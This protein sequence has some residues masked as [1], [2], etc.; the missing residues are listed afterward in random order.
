M[1]KFRR[2]IGFVMV[3]TLFFSLLVLPANA[4]SYTYNYEKE[5]VET[6]EAVVVEKYLDF[7]NIPCGMLSSPEDMDIDNK[8]N[9]YISDTEN[10]RIVILNQDLSF[11]KTITVL[12]GKDGKN[13]DIKAPNGIF[14]ADSGEIYIACSGNNRVFVTN[15]GK[16]LLRT[17][18]A[19]AKDVM[20]DTFT[21]TPLKVAADSSGRTFVIADGVYDGLMQF[22]P[23]GTFIGFSGS[24]KVTYNIIDLFWMWFGTEKQ[25]K[26]RIKN[27]PVEFDGLDMD[28][29]GFV[30]TASGSVDQW[31]P[32][33]SEPIRRQTNVGTNIL[34]FIDELGNPI[35]DIEYPYET[36]EAEVTGPSRLIDISADCSYGY[37]ALDS[38]RGR[39]FVYNDNGDLMFAFGGL[40]GKQGEFV[41]PSAV[42]AT[43]DRIYV[44]DKGTGAVT[45]F[46]FSDYAKLII[47]AQQ[48]YF[49]GDYEQSK[50]EYEEILKLNSGLDLAYAGLGKILILEGDYS[51]AMEYLRFGKNKTYYSKAFGEYRS[52][53]MSD[54]FLIILIIAIIF[55]TLTVLFV[56]VFAP[57]I[58][59][60]NYSL[61][62]NETYRGSKY[63]LHIMTHP[64]D[65]F[66]DMTREKRG[67]LKSATLLYG[68]FVG[69]ML[70]RSSCS[71]FLFTEIGKD[72]DILATLML[73]I[74]P[75]V[76]WCLCNWAVST[77][78][79]G[80]GKL[81]TIYMSG[82]YCLTPYIITAVPAVLLSNFLTLEETM[83]LYVVE[84]FAVLWCVFLLFAAMVTIH[85]YSGKKAIGIIIATIVGMAAVI[86]LIVL[87][88]N[89]VQQMLIFLLSIYNE[90]LIRI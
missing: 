12:K 3:I 4:E 39:I 90:I 24:A 11:N 30:Y 23:D 9:I 17:I 18:T 75:I 51:T 77:L 32:Y 52:Q 6:P 15:D 87:L 47:S 67:N 85:G 34:R 60:K 80:D 53:W 20:R 54:N 28:A 69:L 35:G 50:K 71:G 8:G 41:L 19:S 16:T 38:K 40:S 48:N 56:K 59:A 64:F 65:G 89:I 76:L 29:E 5:A 66:W 45:V 58:R 79:D 36:D 68:V 55:I 27:I 49:D 26:Q 70:I 44:L 46:G 81:S 42:A 7:S 86:F 83:I 72:F 2:A 1:L 25:R 22:E 62:E 10:N 88:F 78:F 74:I 14:C 82:A 63:S 37:C 57:K 73:A 13:Y 21:F 84:G 31:N 61:F 33:K 43:E